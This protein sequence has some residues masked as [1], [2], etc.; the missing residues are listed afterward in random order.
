MTN[1]VASLIV[2]TL[3]LPLAAPAQKEAGK[4]MP[5][6]NPGTEVTL[7]GTVQEVKTQQY[8][9]ETRTHALLKTDY[10][11]FDVHFGPSSFLAARQLTLQKGDQIE[12]TGSRVEINGA[13]AVL[14]REVRKYAASA[15]LRNEQGTPMWSQGAAARMYN[16]AAEGTVTGTVTNVRQCDCG[17]WSGTSAMVNI[18]TETVT[19]LLAPQ[20]FLMQKQLDIN[21]GDQLEITGS[22]MNFDGQDVILAREVRRNGTS[23]ALRNDAGVPLWS[24]GTG[25]SQADRA[26][27]PKP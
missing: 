11:T 4:G 21:Q 19:V 13:D 17:G 22:M 12:V 7:R 15:T 27:P 8:G 6:Y 23:V 16:P 3:A 9:D 1:S 14:A 18:G 2:L 26:A 24:G 25:Q 10:G 5:V 20:R